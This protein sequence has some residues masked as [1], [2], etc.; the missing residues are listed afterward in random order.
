[1]HLKLIVAYSI[2]VQVQIPGVRSFRV[3]LLSEE[4]GCSPTL[5]LLIPNREKTPNGSNSLYYFDPFRLG[6]DTN[7]SRYREAEYKH[8]RVAMLAMTEIIVVPIINRY[9]FWTRSSEHLTPFALPPPDHAIVAN[10]LKLRFNEVFPVLITCGILEVFILVQQ[11][12]KDMPGDYGIG[13]F[14][15]RNKGLHEQQ[16][17]MELEHGRLAMVSFVIYMIL[18]AATSPYQEMS[19]LDIWTRFFG[20]ISLQE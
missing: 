7:F 4:L 6:T 9:P 1:M 15:L 13:Y 16:L 8:G 5:S 17:L 14:G 2:L 3:P 19:W 10:L 12:A 18:D 11:D 20:S